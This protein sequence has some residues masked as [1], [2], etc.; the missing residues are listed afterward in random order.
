MTRPE[1]RG[2]GMLRRVADRT[3]AFDFREWFWGDAIAIEGLLAAHRATGLA[4]YRDFVVGLFRAWIDRTN[5]PTHAD[6][7]VPGSALV[8]LYELT[9]DVEYLDYAR[10]LADL[11]IQAERSPASGAYFYRADR[12]EFHGHMWVDALQL[13]PPFLA[14][15]GQVTGEG[16]YFHEAVVHASAHLRLLQDRDSGLFFHLWDEERGRPNGVRWSR[17]NGWALLGLVDTLA[18]V[19]IGQPGREELEESLRR[20]VPSF[21]ALQDGGGHWHIVADRPDTYLEPSA[22]AFACAALP[23]AIAGGLA[24]GGTAAAVEHG[25]RALDAYLDDD[26]ALWGVSIATWPGDVSHYGAQ[27]VGVQKWGQGPLLL[28]LAEGGMR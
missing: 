13:G 16:A 1:R 12:P 19:P 9:G 24:D 27:P 15:L 26:G 23:R 28:A 25:W 2:A 20:Q 5:R 10:R 18:R 22:A 8:E 4:S 14:R 17:G 3:M 11:L 7:M 21:V 6:H